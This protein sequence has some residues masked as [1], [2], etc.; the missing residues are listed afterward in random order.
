MA[1]RDVLSREFAQRRSK[2][3]SDVSYNIHLILKKSQ[4]TYQGVCKIDFFLKKADTVKLDFIGT[5]K[6]VSVNGKEAAYTKDDYSIN[7]KLIK[8]LF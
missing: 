2:L 8:Q 3:I 4:K 5:V 7:L 6:K 1:G